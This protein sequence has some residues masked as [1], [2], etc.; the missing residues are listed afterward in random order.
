MKEIVIKG[1]KFVLKYSLRV[2]FTFETIAKR[3][4]EGRGLLD[5]Y[6][7]MYSSL[8]CYNDGFSMTFDEFIDICDED[9]SIYKTFEEVLKKSVQ[10]SGLNV[11]E[12][13]EKSKKKA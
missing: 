8:L 11:A 10:K 1:E 2:L 3:P 6:L 4:F 5:M 12:K 9:P 13:D 7:L